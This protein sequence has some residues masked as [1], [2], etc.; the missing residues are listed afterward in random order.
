MDVRVSRPG[1]AMGEPGRDQAAGVDLLNP[2]LA[3]ASEQRMA[4]EPGQR[5]LDRSVVGCFH[6]VGNVWP[7]ERPQ[8]RD[9][10]HRREGQVVP[11]DRGG[12][13][14]RRLRQEA[15]AFPVVQRSPMMLPA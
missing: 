12:L 11:R 14:A 9:R 8:G 2:A 1:V 7:C 13:L 10:L 15:R 4:F 5:V 6:L 3:A